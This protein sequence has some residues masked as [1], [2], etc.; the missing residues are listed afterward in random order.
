[1]LN[2]KRSA[3][4]VEKDTNMQRKRALHCDTQYTV[5]QC[6]SDSVAKDY[7]LS[8]VDT[9]ITRLCTAYITSK[10]FN[11]KVSTGTNFTSIPQSD[12]KY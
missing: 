12:N 8:E 7:T 1:M 10:A 5:A 9:K 3:I 4:D 2:M 6:S 11:F